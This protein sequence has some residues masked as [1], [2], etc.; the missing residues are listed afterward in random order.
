MSFKTLLFAGLVSVLSACMPMMNQPA[1]A[2]A[3]AAAPAA[4]MFVATLS[5][6]NE[7]PAITSAATGTVMLMLD[8]G[9]KKATI[10]GSFA[11]VAGTAAHIHGPAAKTANAG[12]II[13]LKIDGNNLS[14]SA[15]LTDAQIADLKAGLWY[16]NVHSAANPGGEIRGQL[17]KQ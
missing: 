5:G 8:E 17:Q 3:A 10:T 1:P 14:G 16:G 11:G 7:N 6:A 2:P 12:V 13:P 4:T 15:D 9:S